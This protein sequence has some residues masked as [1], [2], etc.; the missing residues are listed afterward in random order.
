M[1]KKGI[2]EWNETS[3]ELSSIETDTKKTKQSETVVTNKL[4][5]DEG[6][7][8][9]VSKKIK[10]WSSSRGHFFLWPAPAQYLRS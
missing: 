6:G 2:R 10:K 7:T 5:V 9:W 3:M 4:L 8:V 1:R